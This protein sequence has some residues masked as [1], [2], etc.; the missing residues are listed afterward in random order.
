M[1]SWLAR[2]AKQDLI[3]RHHRNHLNRAQRA[4]IDWARVDDYHAILD[5]SYES[6]VLLDY[7]LERYNIRAC[8][9]IPGDC[10]QLEA[11]ESATQAEVL[12]ARITNLPWR[13]SS[14]DSVFSTALLHNDR[15]LGN[16]LKE[17]CRVLKHRGQFI[18]TMPG[19]IIGARLSMHM[20][21]KTGYRSMDDNPYML[22]NV[23]QQHGFSD[24]S[25][26]SSCP[27]IIVIIA[28]RNHSSCQSDV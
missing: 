7:Y 20:A 13:E 9:I 23:L 6:T 27:G 14:F 10:H 16:A 24:I 3:T 21:G 17:I 8:G 28:H 2:P 25:M 18:L 12:R 19:T 26:R 11:D 5:I 22:M 15:Y 1:Q 4:I